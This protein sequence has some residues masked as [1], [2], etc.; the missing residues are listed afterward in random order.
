MYLLE[1][2]TTAREQGWGWFVEHAK[3]RFALWWLALLGAADTVFFP[4]SVEAFL[5]VLVL[6]HRER[7]KTFL[8]V[9]LAS[10]VAGAAIGYWLLYL[11]FRS[12]GESLLLSW[13]LSDAYAAAQTIVGAQIFLTMLVASFTPLPDKLFIY[14]AGILGAPFVPFVLGFVLGRGARMAVVTYLVYHFGPAVLESV[15]RYSVYAALAAVAI[16]A[17]YAIVHWNLLPL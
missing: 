12:F 2:I 5:A 17:A 14:A 16:L 15:N 8:A 11:L 1:H 13:G 6:A 4:V 10:S 3:S 9:S 7:W